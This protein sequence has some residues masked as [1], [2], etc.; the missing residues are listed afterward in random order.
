MITPTLTALATVFLLSQQVPA[1]LQASL[2]ASSVEQEQSEPAVSVAEPVT[3]TLTAMPEGADNAM[4]VRAVPAPVIDMDLPLPDLAE[5]AE[6]ETEIEAGT[7]ADTVQVQPLA[8]APTTSVAPAF[9]S[10][11]DR[12]EVLSAIEA[13]L[14]RTTTAQGKFSQ[15][16]SDGTT[17]AGDFALR[18]PGRVRFEYGDP[19]P[20]LIVSD[21]TTVA[22]QDRELE[23]I[24]RVPLASTPLGLILDDS[25]DFSSDVEIINVRR[26]AGKVSVTVQD[27]TGE[28]EG[29]LTMVFSAGTY[30]LLGWLTVAADLQITSVELHEV[31]TNGRIDPRLFRLDEAEDDEDER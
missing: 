26:G 11:T 23:S 21:G 16:N 17:S 4:E 19:M 22:F 9:L 24:D 10:D 31:K 5:P 12:A 3:E 7:E 20:V 13:S 29:E 2:Q 6:A 30:E 8:A 27:P 15:S 25:L 18:R 1:A 28:V 14:S